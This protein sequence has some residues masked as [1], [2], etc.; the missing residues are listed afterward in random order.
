MGAMSDEKAGRPASYVVLLV[1]TIVFTLAGLATLV[2]FAGASYPNVLGYRSLCT[3]TPA[4]TLF[5]FGLAGTACVMR[6][7]LVKRRKDGR[8]DFRSAPMLAVVLIFVLGIAAS[9]WFAQVKAEYTD[10]GS[11]ATAPADS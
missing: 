10:A 1:L 9:F 4:A 7:S 8:P 6:A 3:F 5:C 2:P 11:A